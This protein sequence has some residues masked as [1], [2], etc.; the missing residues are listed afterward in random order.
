MVHHPNIQDVDELLVKG[1]IEPL[2]GGA[3]FTQFNCFMHM[4]TF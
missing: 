4:P 1:D 2:R 3:G